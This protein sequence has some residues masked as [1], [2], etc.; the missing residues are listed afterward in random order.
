MKITFLGGGNM[1]IA[2][3]GG[4]IQR[5]FEPHNLGVIE[6]LPEARAR[7]GEQF[8]INIY[9]AATAEALQCVIKELS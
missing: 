2:L 4:L 8:S 1:A 9:E 5:G 7:L 6:I 3:V